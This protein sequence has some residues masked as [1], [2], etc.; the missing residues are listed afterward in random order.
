MVSVTTRPTYRQ[1]EKPTPT[2]QDAGW[3]SELVWMSLEK[4]KRLAPAGIE[5][6]TVQPV[7]SLYNDYVILAQ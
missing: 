3:A 7:A 6:G 4:K 1:E 5:A 2:K